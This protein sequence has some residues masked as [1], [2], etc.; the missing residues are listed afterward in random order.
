MNRLQMLVRL[1][2]V[3]LVGLPWQIHANAGEKATKPDPKDPPPPSTESKNLIR[4]M[5]ADSC[6]W[7]APLSPDGKLLA[8]G[9]DKCQVFVWD[10]KTGE[11]IRS[12]GLDGGGAVGLLF[13]PDGKELLT[14]PGGAVSD[15]T[16]RLWDVGTGKEVR[17]FTGHTSTV[18]GVAQSRDGK[19]MVSAS[20]DQTV[21]LWDVASG[22][23]LATLTGHT[24]VALRV[25]FSPDN[26][27]V[28]SGSDDASVRIWDTKTKKELHKLEPGGSVY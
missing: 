6:I 5:Q 23:E 26:Q 17:R 8:A 13:R 12:F 18:Y 16:L 24:N 3:L 28:A 2:A 25:A 7:A 22:K 9:T 11:K 15:Y 10:A 14:A 21:R 1:M 4:S 20:A 19:Q 27:T